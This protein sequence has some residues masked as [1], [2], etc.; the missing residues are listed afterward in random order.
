[1]ERLLELRD[2]TADLTA[3]PA[4]ARA[5]AAKLPVVAMVC[6]MAKAS[7]VSTWRDI[8]MVAQC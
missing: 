3:P 8:C 7:G 4:V 5:A 6:S 1:M 2:P